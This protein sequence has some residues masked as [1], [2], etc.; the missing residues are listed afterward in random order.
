[1]HLSGAEL[2]LSQEDFSPMRC[3]AFSTNYARFAPM[4]GK[5][6]GANIKAARKAKGWSLEKLAAAVEPKS[7]YQQIARL[8]SADRPITADWIERI[9][10]AL[11][12][13]PVM[14]MA[15]E[16]S[17]KGGG[18][19]TLDEQVANEVAQTLALVAREGAEPEP[20]I[21]QALALM[22]TELTLTFSEHPAVAADAE[23]A[24][25]LLTLVGRRFVPLVN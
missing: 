4:L 22:L 14:L 24:R 25:P 5:R 12:I 6:I 9:S 16:L 21:V 19:F 13:D 1:M 7:S 17:R 10:A 23:R 15:P 8:E 18:G 20:G 11:E 2:R 3:V